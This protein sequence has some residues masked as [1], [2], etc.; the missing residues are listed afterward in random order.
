[1][2][3]YSVVSIKRTGLGNLPGDEERFDKKGNLKIIKEEVVSEVEQEINEEKSEPNEVETIAMNETEEK[4]DK[5]PEPVKIE[6]DEPVQSTSTGITCYNHDPAN[7]RN[8][9]GHLEIDGDTMAR[10]FSEHMS[11]DLTLRTRAGKICATWIPDRPGAQE[12]ENMDRDQEPATTDPAPKYKDY[13][14]EEFMQILDDHIAA[15]TNIAQVE[16]EIV[17]VLEE[18][19]TYAADEA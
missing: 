19:D 16:T 2:G 8:T 13:G 7:I 11:K 14:E 17:S 9:P 15:S 1:L 6:N 18:A 10:Y 3:T 12:P 5:T 4:G